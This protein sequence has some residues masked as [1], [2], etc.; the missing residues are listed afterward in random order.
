MSKETKNAWLIAGLFVGFSIILL[1]FYAPFVGWLKISESSQDWAN[2]ATYYTGIISPIVTTVGLYFIIRTFQLQRNQ[3]KAFEEQ[4]DDAKE[5]N[6]FN[7]ILGIMERMTISIENTV[8]QEL[9]REGIDS[10]A[11]Y[12]NIEIDINT[13]KQTDLGV[14]LEHSQKMDNVFKSINRCLDFIK[15]VSFTKKGET[16][17]G[18]LKIRE[19]LLQGNTDK[20]RNIANFFIKYKRTIINTGDSFNF[21]VANANIR[22]IYIKKFEEFIETLKDFLDLTSTGETEN[23]ATTV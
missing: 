23:E 8:R 1:L 14:Y 18:I 4:S 20:L 16:G 6:S 5:Q 12:L 15:V 11:E 9:Q 22:E 2:F 10:I 21:Y 13:A 17:K 19:I 7:I 3:L